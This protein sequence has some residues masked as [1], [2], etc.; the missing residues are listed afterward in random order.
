MDSQSGFHFAYKELSL[1]VMYELRNK[2]LCFRQENGSTTES[3]A[4][5]SSTAYPN[6]PSEPS[7]ASK[8]LMQGNEGEVRMAFISGKGCPCIVSTFRFSDV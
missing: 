1:L 6:S 2:L 8:L 4:T 7:S 5:E 3:G